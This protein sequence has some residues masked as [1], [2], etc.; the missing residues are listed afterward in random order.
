MQMNRTFY[1]A[2]LAALLLAS[3]MVVPT[4]QGLVVAPALP[5]VVELGAEPYYYQNGYYY[6]YNNNRWGYANSRSG[7]WA[8]LPR[9]RY[10]REIRYRDHHDDHH[11]DH[12]DGDHNPYNR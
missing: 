12:Q 3:C 5:M 6:Y 2:P 7:P 4:Q 11:D 10:P 9:D 8:D 1:I